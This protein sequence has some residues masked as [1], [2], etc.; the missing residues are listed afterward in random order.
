MTSGKVSQ[1]VTSNQG[2][3]WL[4]LTRP[5]APSL[6]I[7]YRH[8]LLAVDPANSSNVYVNTD[9]EPNLVNQ[10]WI[11]ISGDSGQ[12]WKAAKNGGGDP[13]SGGFDDAGV[14][15]ATGDAGIFR[16][17]VNSP[18]NKGGNLN[19]IEFYSFSLD[20]NNPQTG[21]GLFQD[22]PGVLKYVDAP[23]WKYTQPPVN[24]FGESGKMRVDPTS[25]QNVY[26]L[27]PNPADAVS[28]PTTS[29]RFLHSY[30]FGQTWTPAI[31]GLAQIPFNINGS[32][33]TITDFA[34]FPGKRSIIIDPK[35]K[36]RLLLALTSV[37]ET[38]TG[39]DPN[40]TDPFNG[41]GWRDIGATMGNNGSRVSAI[42][43]AP[44]DS[45][46]VY[47]GTEDG[48]VFETT[49]AGDKNPIWNPV[50]NG[51]PFQGQ[52]IMDLNIDPSNSDHV[53]AV[54]SP[55]MQRDDPAP[56]F[57]GFPH[58]WVYNGADAAWLPI[59]GNLDNKLGGETLAVD[60]NP[61]QTPTTPVLYL[62]TLRGAFQ[63]TD[64]GKTWTRIDSIPRTR[65]TD[66]DFMPNLNLIGAGTIGRGAW[67]TTP[68]FITP[69]S[70]KAPAARTN[71]HA[72]P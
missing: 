7:R 39:G 34:S 45:N 13:A 19:T 20:P 8:N 69:S 36:K 28:S 71:S 15:I 2:L 49:D 50:D 57:S 72:R 5:E 24:I 63:S 44:S 58:V 62:G 37:F 48:H 27:D 21:Y 4:P 42:A 9:T 61:V 56:D 47:A 26:Y 14:F 18:V 11:Y 67:E 6:S 29:A 22:G 1:F 51:S 68:T 12:T 25:S 53:F 31:T 35:N 41:K 3:N 38:T 40:T 16:D 70:A 30:D 17:P 66:L 59:N 65:V 10:E 33:T 54:T 52:R 46:T 43:L 32:L 55:M 23:D 60:W 64:L